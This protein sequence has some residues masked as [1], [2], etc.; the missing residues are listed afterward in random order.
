MG[1][2]RGSWKSGEFNKTAT[3]SKFRPVNVEQGKTHSETFLQNRQTPQAS[4]QALNTLSDY[5]Q[6]EILNRGMAPDQ[7]NQ[8][9]SPLVL[10]SNSYKKGQEII[11]KYNINKTATTSIG[12]TSSFSVSGGG[13]TVRQAPEIYSPLFQIA[14]LQL[15]RDRIT[16]NAWNRNFYDTHPLVRNCINLHATYP[17]GKINIR[18]KNK[19]VEQFFMDM[20]EEMDLLGILQNIANEYWKIGESFPYAELDPDKGVWKDILIQNP[21]YVQV[22]RSVL[23]GEPIISLR[24]DTVLQ[25]L[26]TSNNPA[27]IQLRRQ[28]SPEIVHHVRKGNNIPLDNTNVSHLKMVSSPYDIRGTSLIVSVYKDLMLYDKLRESKFAQADNLV[29]PITLVKVGGNNDGEYR[30]TQADLEN[31]RQTLECYDEETEVLTD[32]GFRKYWE[33]IDYTKNNDGSYF[34]T[35]NPEYKIA[36]FNKE[37]EKLEY[38]FPTAASLYDYE[39]EMFHFKGKKLDVKVTPNH[40]MLVSKKLKSGWSDWEIVQAKD[41]SMGINY[42]FRSVV[43]FDGKEKKY[44]EVCG[45]KIKTDDYLE[46]L[47]NVISEGYVCKISNKYYNSVNLYQEAGTKEHFRMKDNLD[48]IARCF[49]KG[50][51]SRVYDNKKAPLSNIKKKNRMWKGI[52]YDAK[53]VRHLFSEI[54]ENGKCNSHNKRIPRWV[55]SL[56]QRQMKILLESLVAGDGSLLPNKNGTMGFR[57]NTISK[58]LAHDVCELAF[59][60]GFAP[61]VYETA[62]GDDKKYW[63]VSWSEGAKGRFPS[64]CGYHKSRSARIFKEHYSG[65]VWCFSVPAGLFITKRK[66][67][68]IIQGNSAAYD[69]D[70]KIISHGGVTIERIGASGSIID[71]AGDMNFIVDNILYGLMT[72]KAI[73]TQEGASFSSASIGLEVLK[74]RYESFRNMMAKWLKMK[75]FA[76]ISEIQDF[77]EYRDGS[78]KLIVPEVDWNQMILFDMDNYIQALQTLSQPDPRT[79]QKSVSRQTL[80]HSLGLDYE[81][82]KKKI[83]E[84]MIQDAIYV[85]E[86]SIVQT[87]GLST[88]RALKSDEE[89]IEPTEAQPLP[90]TPGFEAG[91]LPGAGMPGMGP[92]MD[93]GMPA[94]PGVGGGGLGGAGP[95]PEPGGLAGGLGGEVPSAGGGVGEAGGAGGGAAGV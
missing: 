14:N 44:I 60:A 2:K 74:Q 26:V 25:R 7:D 4:G 64:I 52:L 35:P 78:K 42:R 23:G 8:Y 91:G 61:S 39:G 89:I 82:E 68:L 6:D 66:N 19:K 24:P 65:K 30:A 79:G 41:M 62:N 17:L 84:E 47:G 21:D 63:V 29:N 20:M 85:K 12:G 37:T 57:Y 40:R 28:I 92:M 75:I 51:K 56:S 3:T 94:L 16:M 31:W 45:N 15:P 13:D 34:A 70:F 32:K 81:D 88:L 73:L 83:R 58:N 54:G 5:R 95:L 48:K 87:M 80:F 9:A 69:K 55:Y 22:K 36:C 43:G 1:I 53:L 76:P 10:Y 18:C 33:V 49:R 86:Q 93:L 50:V 71:I 90:G 72:P 67:L 11:K 27:D 46:F 59:L 38:H 77:Y